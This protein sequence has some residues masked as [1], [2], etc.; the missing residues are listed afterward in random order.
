MH[1][2]YIAALI[3]MLALVACGGNARRAADTAAA[4]T[5]A[6]GAATSAGAQ[7]GGMGGMPMGSMATDQMSAH[8]TAM[9]GAGG[10]SL[11]RMMDMHRQMTANMIARFNREMSRMSMPGD[12]GWSATVDSLRQDLARMP[13]LG[14]AEMQLMM[15]GHHARVMRLMAM[16]RSMMER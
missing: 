9:R 6:R 15:P 11:M 7:M 4:D 14:P 2:R 12:A 1:I 10:D 16:H 8:M 3:A 13:E 5:G